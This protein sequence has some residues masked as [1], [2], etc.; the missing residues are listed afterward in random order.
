MMASCGQRANGC[1]RQHQANSSTASRSMTAYAVH[2]ML[3]TASSSKNQAWLQIQ[4]LSTATLLLLTA[5]AAL[6]VQMAGCSLRN[7]NR[8]WFGTTLNKNDKNN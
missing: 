5:V 2:A 1:Y 6:R 4:M 8:L 7:D 3:Y